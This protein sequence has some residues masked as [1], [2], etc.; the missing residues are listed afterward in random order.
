MANQL[1]KEFI[2]LFKNWPLDLTKRGRCFGEQIRKHFS[3]EF[4]KGELSDNIDVKYWT[5]TLKDLR[6]ISENEFFN[7]YPRRK[8]TGALGLGRE[9]CKITL[10]NDALKIMAERKN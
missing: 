7:K 10:S 8:A 2:V 6:A 9:Q 5:K 1:F 3:Q 4:K